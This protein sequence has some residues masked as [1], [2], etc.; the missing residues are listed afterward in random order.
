[1]GLKSGVNLNIGHS[2]QVGNQDFKFLS[3]FVHRS[4]CTQTFKD[5]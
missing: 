4:I 5:R 2:L 1:M 3:V